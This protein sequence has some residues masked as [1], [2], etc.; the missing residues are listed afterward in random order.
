[1]D[2][3]QQT[4]STPIIDRMLF[5]MSAVGLAVLVSLAGEVNAF[6][7]VAITIEAAAATISV[8]PQ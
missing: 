8:L 4:Q 6:G 7:D 1:M 5:V 2:S 3:K